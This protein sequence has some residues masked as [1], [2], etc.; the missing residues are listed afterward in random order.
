MMWPQ[1]PA[2]DLGWVVPGARWI[3]NRSRAMFAVAELIEVGFSSG[4]RL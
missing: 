4:E 2:C 1:F 3:W